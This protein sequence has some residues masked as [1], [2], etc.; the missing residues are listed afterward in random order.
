MKTKDNKGFEALFSKNVPHLLEKIFFS[1]DYESYKRCLEVSNVWHDLLT[2]DSFQ[3]KGKYVFHTEIVKD[4]VNLYYAAGDGDEA[5][6]LKVLSTRMIDVNTTSLCE[7]PLTRASYHGQKDIV[8][9]LFDSGADLNKTDGNGVS[10]LHHAA[11]REKID[12]VQLLIKLGAEPQL[13]KA[14]KNGQ[15][16]ILQKL[17]QAG[18]NPNKIELHGGEFPLLLAAMKG[19]KNIVQ[20]LLQR[21]A[22]PNVGNQYG[23]TPLHWAARLDRKAVVKQLID[24]GADPN[25]GNIWG[26]TPLYKAVQHG[27]KDVVKLLVDIGADKSIA[28]EDGKS[29]LTLAQEKDELFIVNVLTTGEE[30]GEYP[31][32]SDWLF[33]LFIISLVIGGTSVIIFLIKKV[34]DYETNNDYEYDYDY[35]YDYG[36]YEK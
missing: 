3:K 35:D 34:V 8:Q 11:S 33:L 28:D 9:L 29:P 21:G 2:S 24:G 15:Y 23:N 4:G 27:K 18:A 19:Q 26:Q 7:T 30:T 31:S 17:L 13:W 6:A 14:A 32:V 10:P 20:L 1:L 22:K 36:D 25:I 5:K 16:D 12:T